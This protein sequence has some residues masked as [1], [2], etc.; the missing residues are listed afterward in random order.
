[1]SN[2]EILTLTEMEQKFDCYK[3]GTS[4]AIFDL[5]KLDYFN[6]YYI[7]Q[8]EPIELTRL[9]RPYLS[10]NIALTTNEFKKTDEF[11]G[12]VI[13]LERDRMKKLSEIGNF[14]KFFFV[15]NLT[16]DRDL[17]VW[18]KSTPPGAKTALEDLLKVL[19]SISEADWQTKKLEEIVVKYIK[20]NNKGVGVFVWPMRVALTGEKASQKSKVKDSPS[21]FF[22]FNFHLFQASCP[23]LFLLSLLFAQEHEFHVPC[24]EDCSGWTQE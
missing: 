13:A 21:P 23:A 20:D 3:L 5:D 15:D 12:K 10:E 18:K 17:L 8:L 4:P 9:C 2:P 11:V 6:G 7:R 1:M 19:D 22:D 16:Y 24:S 14:T